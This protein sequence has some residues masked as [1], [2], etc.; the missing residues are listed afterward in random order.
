MDSEDYFK[1]AIKSYCK[2]HNMSPQK[3]SIKTHKN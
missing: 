2:R 3:T 1:A